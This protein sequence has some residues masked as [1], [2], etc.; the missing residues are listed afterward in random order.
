MLC[1]V[2]LH[3]LAFAVAKFGGLLAM[4]TSNKCPLPAAISSHKNI[5]RP[6]QNGDFCRRRTDD[7]EVS[8][9]HLIEP[10]DGREDLYLS[11]KGR[12]RGAHGAAFFQ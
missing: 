10:N 4:K 3:R 8:N 11:R 1:A 2:P 5:D 6:A 7:L 9:A 12:Q